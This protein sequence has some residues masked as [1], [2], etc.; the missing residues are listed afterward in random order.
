M[1]G[2]GPGLG[3]PAAGCRDVGVALAVEPLAPLDARGEQAVLLE[4]AGQRQVDAGALAQF[5]EIELQ[6]PVAETRWAAALPRRSGPRGQLLANH[7]ERQELVAL[8]AQDRLQPLDVVLAEEP[9]AAARALRGQ[10]AL[11]LEI[12]DLRDRDVR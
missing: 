12:A 6:L 5:A 10:E 7:A 1:A 9:V 2:I 11:I 8:Q 4:R 3:Q